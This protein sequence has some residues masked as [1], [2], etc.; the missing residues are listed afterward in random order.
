MNEWKVRYWSIQPMNAAPN[1]T[2]VIEPMP[3]KITKTT[4]VIET[5]RAKFEGNTGPSF[6]DDST[7][8][9]PEVLAPMAK[10]ITLYLRPLMPSD[11]A[12]VSSSRMAAQD[13]PTFE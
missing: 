2:P 10:A 13:R 7:P 4:T 12:A 6:A 3:P 1:N 11:R 9:T 8:A 5:C